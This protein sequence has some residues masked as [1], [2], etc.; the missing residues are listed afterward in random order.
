VS[1][2]SDTAE[3]RRP[4]QADVEFAIAGRGLQGALLALALA[5]RPVALIERG[6]TLGSNHLW[7]F[8]AGDVAAEAKALVDSLGVARCHAVTIAC[9]IGSCVL[10]CAAYRLGAA[11]AIPAAVL[12][13]LSV[14]YSLVDEAFHW[15]RYVSARSDRVEMRSHV[16]IFV[17]DLTML[18]AWWV[19]LLAGYPSVAESL[20]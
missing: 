1:V 4:R 6:A 18:S 7:S 19:S 20:A 17:G 13:A 16:F 3:N 10:L 14:L 15:Q 9:G 11:A 12:T 5:G 2:L 8:H